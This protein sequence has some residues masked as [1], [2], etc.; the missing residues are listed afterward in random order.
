[1]TPHAETANTAPASAPRIRSIQEFRAVAA[2]MVV[3]CHLAFVS[4]KY[5]GVQNGF[6]ETLK[7]WGATGV[8]FFFIISGVVIYQVSLQRLGGFHRAAQFLYRRATRIYPTYWFYTTLALLLYLRSPAMINHGTL[9]NASI[10]P[11]YLLSSAKHGLLIGQAWTLIFEVIF[12]LV[13]AVFILL[14][15]K[16]SLNWLLALWAVAIVAAEFASHGSIGVRW[17]ALNP[18][19]LEFLLGCLI[20][21]LLHLNRIGPRWGMALALFGFFGTAATTLWAVLE[22][23]PAVQLLLIPKYRVVGFG[24][25]FAC[26]VLG[27]LAL[28]RAEKLPRR[29]WMEKVGDWSYSIY[30]LHVLLLNAIFRFATELIPALATTAGSFLL[31]ACGI[32]AV[33]LCGWASY[34]FLEKP[35]LRTTGRVAD[36]VW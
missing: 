3:G 14:A 33:L 1:M 31:T 20:A 24:L 12:Y 6:L 27:V 21:A 16:R 28:E 32:V 2:L 23:M 5:C 7:W 11:S 34:R 19:V 30:L 10:L 9:S 15:N 35:V 8:D 25:P 13:F 17:L 22:G 36:W 26:L 18:Q 4:G 29:P